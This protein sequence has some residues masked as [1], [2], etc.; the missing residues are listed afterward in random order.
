MTYHED[1]VRVLST[2]RA[3]TR[4]ESHS[5]EPGFF[6]IRPF[7]LGIRFAHPHRPTIRDAIGKQTLSN[8]RCERIISSRIMKRKTT[9]RAVGSSLNPDAFSAKIMFDSPQPDQA[10][11]TIEFPRIASSHLP[12]PYIHSTSELDRLEMQDRRCS[13]GRSQNFFL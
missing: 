7:S 9:C 5:S 8:C 4:P 12:S 1:I 11:H 3:Q 6:D 13:I 10:F 2:T